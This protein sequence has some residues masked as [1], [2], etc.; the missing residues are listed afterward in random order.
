M[1]I[2]NVEGDLEVIVD[3]ISSDA[4]RVSVGDP[5]LLRDWGRDNELRGEVVRVDPY[6]VTKVSALGIEEQRVR[7]EIALTSPPEERAGLGHRYRLE[8]GIIVWQGKNVLAVPSSALFRT[9]EGWTVFKAINGVATPQI[10]RTGMSDGLFTV[11]EV[12]LEPGEQVVL[13][14]SVAVEDGVRIESR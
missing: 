4:V 6:G 10:V 7:V 8:V 11:V 12:G 9:N 1:E 5:V 13:Y 14:P 2:G 3:L